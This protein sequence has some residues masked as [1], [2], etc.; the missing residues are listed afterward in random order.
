[1]EKTKKAV[2]ECKN[3]AE[4]AFETSSKLIE[5]KTEKVRKEIQNLTKK[6]HL[7]IDKILNNSEINL[8]TNY[9]KDMTDNLNKSESHK[10]LNT[11]VQS[12]SKTVEAN[13]SQITKSSVDS[14]PSLTS[15]QS[16]LKSVTSIF[17][18]SLK[19]L[20]SKSKSKREVEELEEPSNSNE[21]NISEKLTKV[22]EK[23]KDVTE[24]VEK[25]VERKSVVKDHNSINTVQ[26]EIKETN[27]SDILT[28]SQE[29][30]EFDEAEA[31]NRLE[32]LKQKSL[33]IAETVKKQLTKKFD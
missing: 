26:D 13:K 29:S 17:T 25:Q 10:E 5:E 28:S 30:R 19:S 11:K 1:M 4:E 20:L 9:E 18:K 22:L 23:V 24:P 6:T 3:T 16:K 8:K 2:E 33:E 31:R 32:E 27:K 7:E 21:E 12:T 14:L 15:K